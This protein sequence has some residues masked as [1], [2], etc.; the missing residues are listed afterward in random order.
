VAA[1]IDDQ[2]EERQTV[3]LMDLLR[4]GDIPDLARVPTRFRTLDYILGGGLTKRR[5]TILA[6]R[7][8]VGKTDFAL[9]IARNVLRSGHNIYLAALEADAHETLRR[10]Q[11]AEGNDD[12]IAAYR[13]RMEIN[14]RA[15]STVPQ[16]AAA[17]NSGNFDLVIVDYL[18][19][20]SYPH[21]VNGYY[22]KAT[23]LSNQVR[24]ASKHSK[25][26]WL[27]LSQFSREVK[28]EHTEPHISALR[29]SGAIE[30]DAYAVICLWEPNE[31]GEDHEQLTREVSLKVA[32]NRGGKVGKMNM[33]FQMAA[34]RWE[35]E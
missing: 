32:K 31:R 14:D 15:D 10:I 12:K 7:P 11:N 19:N 2:I 26:A 34:S 8:G 27:V 29:D 18:Q 13:G 30:Q 6:A 17:V 1:I 4:E 28:D 21:R 35:E 9:A 25:A 22:E 24:V 3:T 20:L 23:A 33:N 16:I 5:V